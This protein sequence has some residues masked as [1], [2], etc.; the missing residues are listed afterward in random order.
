MTLGRPRHHV[1]GLPAPP[2]CLVMG[3]VNV[4]PDSFSDGGLYLARDAAVA[5]GLALVDEGAD[6]VDVGG[7]RAGQAG[8]QVSA[9]QEIGR[10]VPFLEAARTAYPELVLSLDT[11]RSE[12]AQ[13]AEGLVDVVNDTWAGHYPDLVHVAARIGAGV[14]CSH[15][16][17][18]P[19]RTDPV[20]MRYADEHGDDELA[21]VR[22]VLRVLAEGARVAREAVLARHALPRFLADWD[23]LLDDVRSRHRSRTGTTTAGAGAAAPQ[24]R[25]N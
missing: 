2:R 4:T 22:D 12:V 3:V 9:E 23:E 8:E 14:V 17:G 7:V 20:G 25:S 13:A 15:T 11:W 10:V 16:G 24:G 18:L 21:V 19:P 6:L 5:R 1:E